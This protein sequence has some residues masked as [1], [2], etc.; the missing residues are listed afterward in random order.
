M[1]QWLIRD[2]K[3]IHWCHMREKSV[4]Q[5]WLLKATNLHTYPAKISQFRIIYV[6]IGNKL[7]I[8]CINCVILK[9]FS[10]EQSTKNHQRTFAHFAECK[11]HLW[12][13]ISHMDPERQKLQTWNAHSS[14]VTQLL[15]MRQKFMWS[16]PTYHRLSTI[17]RLKQSFLKETWFETWS[18]AFV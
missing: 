18:V 6:T 4:G 8:M 13:R 12:L 11:K 1:P 14:C 15:K 7:G 3:V 2:I 16:W 5:M 10:T 9:W 17:W